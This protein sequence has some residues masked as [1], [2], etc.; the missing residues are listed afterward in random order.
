MLRA[1]AGWLADRSPLPTTVQAVCGYYADSGV[2][3]LQSLRL[4]RQV[5]ATTEAMIRDAFREIEAALAAEFDRES[6]SF[7]YDTKL[8]LPA[9]LTLGDLLR[10]LDDDRRD[11][12]TALTR[13]A[14]EALV[15]GDMRDARNDDEFEDFEVDI[16]PSVAPRAAVARVAQETLRDRVTA[17][18]ERFD[19]EVREI[20]DWA[21]SVSETHQAEDEAFRGLMADAKA[22]DASA[23]ER[24]RAE[25]KFADFESDPEVFTPEELELPY[26]KTQ[27]DRVGVIYD[28]MVR[29]YRAADLPVADAFHRSIV[30][31]IIGAQLWLDDIDDYAAD[32]REGQLTPVTAE[33]LLAD[34]ET[35]AYDRIVDISETY[36]AL[37]GERATAADSPLTGIA[38]E[39]IHRSGSPGVLP[40]SH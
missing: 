32:M 7:A 33:Y 30:L 15:D 19:A 6:V 16:P 27:Y 24:I 20:Y 17:R 36:L 3:D 2:F 10:R 8:V 21:V 28:G 14:I 26:V 35:A 25:Y 12:A 11:R 29:M 4:K 22:G 37:A 39:Y 34:D 1:G 13:L 9:Q 5:D 18:F 40:G 38:T 23:T 31:A